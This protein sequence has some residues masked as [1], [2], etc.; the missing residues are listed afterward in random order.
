MGNKLPLT[1]PIYMA[2]LGRRMGMPAREARRA[3][4]RLEHER[5]V[6]VLWKTR[7]TQRGRLWTTEAVLSKYFPQLIDRPKRLQQET[8]AFARSVT[9]KL[10]EIAAQ[11]EQVKAANDEGLSEVRGEIARIKRGGHE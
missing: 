4:R 9:E 7:R 1:R 6:R 11:L 5:R 8:R 10:E 2:E 3:L